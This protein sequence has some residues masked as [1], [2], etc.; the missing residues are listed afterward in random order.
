MCGVF[1]ERLR[2][3]WLSVRLTTPKIPTPDPMAVSVGMMS[4]FRAL[5]EKKQLYN[6]DEACRLKKVQ[7]VGVWSYIS[8]HDDLKV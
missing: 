6:N 7:N 1:K 3:L 2:S 4:N 5:K 8:M